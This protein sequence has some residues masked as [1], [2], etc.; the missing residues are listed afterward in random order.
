M[1]KAMTILSMVAAAIIAV[2]ILGFLALYLLGRS[3]TN[4]EWQNKVQERTPAE[5]RG[6][7]QAM[8]ESPENTPNF[9]PQSMLDDE[10]CSAAVCNAINFTVGK[11]L[12][13]CGAAWRFSKT[14]D[15]VIAKT[16]YDRSKDFSIETNEDGTRRIVENFDRNFWLD[17]ILDPSKMYVVGYH[18]HNTVHDEEILEDGIGLNSH[19][20]WLLP[21]EDNKRWAYHLVHRPNRLDENPYQI[22]PVQD[23]PSEFD[24]VYI[25]ELKGIVLPEKGDKMILVN[26]SLPFSKIRHWLNNGPDF[27][28][29]YL[30]TGMVWFRNTTGGYDQF[31]EVMKITGELV[32]LPYIHPLEQ[33]TVLAYYRHIPIF[34]HVYETK[35]RTGYGQKYQCVELINRFY[36]EILGHKNMQG[37]GHADSY[38]WQASSKAKGLKAYS[39][40]SK[41]KPAVHDI[42]VFDVGNNDGKVGHAA[43]VISVSNLEVCFIQQ[44]Y[45]RD[46]EPVVKDCLPLRV[47]GGGW[48]ILNKYYAPVAGWSRIK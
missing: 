3:S 5:I 43:L 26:N 27:M 30:D 7:M 1:K 29:Y 12:L 46:N 28:E 8:V 20:A 15:Q 6:L 23:L 33:G 44:N 4:R 32:E 21:I 40:G 9:V 35:E 14:N 31:P 18:Y 38:F 41:V 2:V 36:A 17:S 10:V 48:H 45:Y 34:A 22:E 47:E 42:L 19:L 13:K 25:W 37:T 39:N 11:E 24:L 16:V